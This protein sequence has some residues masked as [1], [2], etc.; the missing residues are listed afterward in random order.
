[1]T[2]DETVSSATQIKITWDDGTSDGGT[3]IIDYRVDYYEDSTGVWIELASG[4]LTQE[5]TTTIALT[6]GK[7]YNMGVRARNTV[8]Y[9]EY[10]TTLLVLAAQKPD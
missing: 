4:L 7:V 8:G 6:E 2:N 3:S 5:Y 1:M 10:S 9:S